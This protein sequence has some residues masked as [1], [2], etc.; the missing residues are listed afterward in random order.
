MDML[1]TI[2]PIFAVI[3]LIFA[4]VLAIRVNRQNPGTDRMKEIATAISEGAQ[5]FLTAEY[6]I[7]KR[8]K[9]AEYSICE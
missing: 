7:R 2:V 1:L 9:L 8:G 5:A 6:K 4:G 3:A